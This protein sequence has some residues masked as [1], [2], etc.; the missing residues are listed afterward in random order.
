[1]LRLIYTIATAISLLG[2]YRVYSFVVSPLLRPLVRVDSRPPATTAHRGPSEAAELA[3]RHL[4]NSPWAAEAQFC[5]QQSSDSCLFANVVER[6]PDGG[7]KVRLAPFAMVWRDPRRTDGGS[8]TMEATGAVVHFQN[9]FF[10]DALELSDKKPGRIVHMTLEGKVHVTGPDNLD[11]TGE[12]FIFSE[13]SAQLYSDWPISFRYGPAPG[14]PNAIR[15]Q[16]DQV[17]IE[18]APVAVSPYGPE[19][20]HIGEVA[21]MRLRRSVRLDLTYELNG[22]PAKTLVSSDGPFSYDFQQKVAQFEDRVT[23]T[24]PQV[25]NGVRHMDSLKCQWLGLQFVDAPATG[26][27]GTLPLAAGKGHS[28]AI[29]QASA[30]A[31]APSAPSQSSVLSGIAFRYL[32]ALAARESKSPGSVEPVHVE[33]SENSFSA[34]AQELR[35]DAF[36]REI[37]LADPREVRVQHEATQILAPQMRVI[38][39]QSGSRFDLIECAGAGRF[40]QMDQAREHLMFFGSWAQSVQVVPDPESDG[41]LLTI[42]GGASLVQPDR[43]Q[44]DGRTIQVWLDPFSSGGIPSGGIP[45]AGP[46]SRDARLRK[47]PI[48]R[49]L[50]NGDVQLA[51]PDV[52]VLSDRVDARFAEGTVAPRG[53]GADPRRRDGG[54]APQMPGAKADEPPFVV[55]A[56][57]IDAVVI[58]D[59]QT[60]E[61][62][63]PELVGKHDVRITRE[64]TAPDARRGDRVQVNGPVEITGQKLHLKSEGGSRQVLTLAGSLDPQPGVPA[65]ARLRIGD[66]RVESGVLIFDRGQ[67]RV[68][69]PGPGQ[70]HLPVAADMRGKKLDQPQ[71]MHVAWIERMSFDGQTA[72]FLQNVKALL[73]DSQLT[74]EAMDVA[75]NRRIDFQSDRPSTTG[76]ELK[77][78]DCRHQ[79]AIEMYEYA[80]ARIVEVMKGTLAHFHLDNGTGEFEGL[81]PGQVQ[82]WRIA[83]SGESSRWLSVEPT[84]SARANQ[85]SNED[86]RFPWNYAQIVFKGKVTGNVQRQDATLHRNVQI[87]YAPVSKALQVFDRNDLSPGS[88]KDNGEN[89][90][91]LGCR[92]LDILLTKGAAGESTVQ[93]RARGGDG[94][95]AS[96]EGR[97]FTASG[98]EVLYDQ[99]KG[100][101]IL[102][103]RGTDKADIHFQDLPGQPTRDVQARVILFVPSR[104]ELVLDGLSAS[105]QAQ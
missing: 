95:D 68:E 16:A 23:V 59:P 83:K 84:S 89:G 99:A 13:E 82:D 91:W 8:Y 22:E 30:T 76:L 3:G 57:Q 51:S 70:L 79:V 42:Q 90:A 17:T 37:V 47:L 46:P 5:W 21:R 52:I 54:D 104:R 19:M 63:V 34:D 2:V 11:I 48:R 29:E 53:R 93:L 36:T 87:L 88:G 72:K 78:I 4:A 66:Y 62:D 98:N 35:Y 71:I 49:A 28:T 61:I 6:L 96:L 81:G 31:A 85:P 69:V 26:G 32:R 65:D 74:C 75:L 45:G 60:A 55:R 77:S 12:K 105:G 43:M 33:S 38:H 80:D 39:G 18:F 100:Q 97:K 1:M 10:D 64:A 86:K 27:A 25:K 20:P 73:G 9:S 94:E 24:R 40:E 102:R 41:N 15:G 50:A 101:F 44:I 67:N 7:N 58:H 103:G 92:E 56:R 14:Q